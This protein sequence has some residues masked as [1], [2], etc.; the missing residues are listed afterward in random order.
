MIKFNLKKRKN[1]PD[2]EI[3]YKINGVQATWIGKVK[4]L[5]Y[6]YPQCK[7]ISITKT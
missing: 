7:I 1:D 5:I 6:T 4:N 3:I 2:K